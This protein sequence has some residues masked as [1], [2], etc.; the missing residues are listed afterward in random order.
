MRGGGAVLWE[1]SLWVV[2]YAQSSWR[3]SVQEA[4]PDECGSVRTRFEASRETSISLNMAYDGEQSPRLHVMA[5]WARPGVEPCSGMRRVELRET[6]ATDAT[7]P[8]V[9]RGDGGLVVELRRR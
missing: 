6:V 7:A 2:P 3:Q 9:L 5:Q 1:G 8:I 4:A